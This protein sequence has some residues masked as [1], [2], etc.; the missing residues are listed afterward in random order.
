MSDAQSTAL[1][2]SR[3]FDAASL[4]AHAAPECL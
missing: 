1:P 3:I 2:V 4:E